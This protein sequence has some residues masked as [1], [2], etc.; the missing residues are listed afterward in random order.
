MSQWFIKRTNL[1]SILELIN[2]E[3]KFTY[4]RDALKSLTKMDFDKLIVSVS[5]SLKKSYDFSIL[6]Q[7][8]SSETKMMTSAKPA[9]QRILQMLNLCSVVKNLPLLRKALEGSRSQL[10]QIVH[11]V[12]NRSQRLG[13]VTDHNS[14]VV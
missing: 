8:A 6:N 9:S 5:M 7:L 12:G 13:T 10:L 14:D 2:A 3:D 1:S 4:I 11:D